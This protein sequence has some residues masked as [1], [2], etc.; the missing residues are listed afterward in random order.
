MDSILQNLDG[1]NMNVQVPVG[2]VLAGLVAVAAVTYVVKKCVMLAL[3]I[4]AKVTFASVACGIL[5]LGGLSGTGYSI[6]EFASGKVEKQEKSHNYISNDELLRLASNGSVDRDRL[7][8]VLDYANQ[9]DKM[10][11]AET[12]THYVVNETQQPQVSEYKDYKQP[13]T[14]LGLSV[15]MLLTSLVWF[16]R[17]NG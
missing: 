13:W 1:L 9:R 4:A 17:A 11:T 3:A 2:Y 14:I 10:T 6:G 8:L 5:L 7:K 12:K 16:I 15:S